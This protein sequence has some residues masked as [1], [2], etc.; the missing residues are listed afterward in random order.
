MYDE[1]DYED[2]KRDRDW[3]ICH[4]DDLPTE[5]QA[6]PQ[7]DRK[8][9]SGIVISLERLQEL[10]LTLATLHAWAAIDSELA[11]AIEV[12]TDSLRDLIPP[13]EEIT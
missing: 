5:V 4:A 11:Q 1:E 12:V 7:E 8:K 9:P 6:L 13:W 10:R 3:E 2:Y